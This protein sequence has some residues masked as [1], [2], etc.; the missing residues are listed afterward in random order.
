L[1]ALGLKVPLEPG[2][3]NPFEMKSEQGG[4]FDWSNV[5]Q[6]KVRILSDRMFDASKTPDTIR[7]EYWQKFNAM[8]GKLE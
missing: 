7:Q 5:P 8:K 2:P 4:T 1:L 3:L 6:S